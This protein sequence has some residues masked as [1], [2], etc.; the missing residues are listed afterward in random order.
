MCGSVKVGRKNPKTVWWNKGVKDT[1]RR[2][3]AASKEV[4][5]TRDEEAKKVNERF[6]KKMRM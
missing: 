1:L 3:E 2:K 4:L 5:A 6:R